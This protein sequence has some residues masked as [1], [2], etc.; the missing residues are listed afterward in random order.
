MKTIKF[1]SSIFAI[2]I[3]MTSCSTNDEILETET[4][5]ELLKSFTIAKN[6][7]GKYAV[8]YTTNNA[9]SQVVKNIKSN[10]NEIFLYESATKSNDNFS[11]ALDLNNN[12]LNIDFVDTNTGKK[13]SITIFDDNIV[14]AKDNGDSS[15]SMLEDYSVTG[16]GDGT[17]DLAFTVKN[18]IEVDFVY[19]EEISTYEIH[20][21]KGDGSNSDFTRTFSSD[22]NEL[23]I[24]F[25]NHK[26]V[27]A[28]GYAY[29]DVETAERKPRVIIQDFESN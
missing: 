14:F 7:Q 29:R 9:T 26:N 12:T 21:V 10:T 20:L 15:N 23:K 24:D 13:P 8:D 11:E 6:A 28:K 4:S 25:V 2:A 17:Y 16:N 1:L 19:N 3:F 27:A 18:K 5:S 22:G